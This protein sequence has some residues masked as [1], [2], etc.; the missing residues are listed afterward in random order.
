M[1]DSLAECQCNKGGTTDQICRKDGGNC[2]CKPFISGESCDRCL[3]GYYGYPECKEGMNLYEI[4]LSIMVHFLILHNSLKNFQNVIAT[5]I[6]AI[7]FLVQI[8]EIVYAKST[9][10]GRIAMNV[11]QDITTFQYANVSNESI[12]FIYL[13]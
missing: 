10:R 1:S 12:F 6:Q 13:T 2:L 9:S 8:L 5:E 3:D 11:H 4:H 7:P